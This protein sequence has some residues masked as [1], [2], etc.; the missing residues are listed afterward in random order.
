[1]TVSADSAYAHERRGPPLVSG[2]GLVTP[3]SLAS[4]IVP[5]HNEARVIGRLLSQLVN[6]AQPGELDVIVVANGCSDDTVEVAASFGPTVRVISLPVASKREALAAGNRVA[7]GFPR[8]YVDADVELRAE[9]AREL[10]AALRRPGVLAAAP[11]V[12][13]AMTGRPWSVRWHYD[14]WTRLPEVRRGLFG[15]GVVAVSEAGYARIADLPPV[16]ADD[17]AASLSFSPDERVIAVHAQ[18]VIHPPLAFTD[19]M[20]V[21]IRAAMGVAQVETT[22]G[23]PAS[24]ARTRPRDLL[25]IVRRR[26]RLAPKVSLFL[27]VALLA[28]L[29]ARRAVRKGNYSEWLRDESSRRAV[30]MHREGVASGE[31]L[32]TG[33]FG[34]RVRVGDLWFDRLTEKQVIDVVRKAW[35]DGRGGSIIPVNVDVARKAS[36]AP[37]LGQLVGGGSIVI[38]DG[39]PL[40]WASRLAGDALPERVAGSTLLLTL[41]AAAADEGRS[42]FLLGGADGVATRAA[43]ALVARSP[44]LRI[45][46]TT[47]P[48]FGFDATQEG[49]LETIASV[50]AVQPDLVFVGLGFPRQERLIERLRQAWPEAWYVAC[51][52]GIP[53]AAGVVR[54]ASPAVQRLGLEWVHRLALEPRRLVRRYLWDDLP[55][56]VALLARS[57]MRRLRP[58][59][60][61]GSF[62]SG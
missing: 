62:R 41:T 39:M 33:S 56:A 2:S 24:T 47:S 43:D 40:V 31:T 51:G 22:N 37:A 45:A 57:A 60:S 35:A 14:V 10:A 27:A 13:L 7:L 30:T 58:D 53:M 54:R 38:A 17:L 52:G 25:A 21:R 9:D 28:R 48:P 8:I 16:L 59:P 1:M 55:F 61:R 34:H 42:V 26:P 6:S 49:V 19:L 46:G 11:E 23:A 18:V 36:R 44:S 29:G 4:V 15:R 32:A 20:R 12:V 5:A 3:P 50:A